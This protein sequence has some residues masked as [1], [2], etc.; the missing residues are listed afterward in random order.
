MSIALQ[1]KYHVS[2]EDDTIILENVKHFSTWYSGIHGFYWLFDF[3]DGHTEQFYQNE[4]NI[5]GASI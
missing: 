1:R 2:V 3:V 5:C 4:W